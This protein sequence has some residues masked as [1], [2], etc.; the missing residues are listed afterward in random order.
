LKHASPGR[1]CGTIHARTFAAA[2]ALKET[3]MRD[4]IVALDLETTG[5]NRDEDD[6]IEIGAA[7][8]ENG[9]LRDTF[10]TLVNPGRAIPERVTAITG[11]ETDDLI[12]QPSIRSVLPGLEAFIGDR[13]VL[14]HRVDF[15]LGFLARYSVATR[16]LP[17]DTYELAS[18]L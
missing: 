2:A 16:N 7:L 12:G 18:V 8:F 10:S 11:I 17:I 4:A 14:G 15:D 3:S 9:E 5:L 1:G 6:I 13:P